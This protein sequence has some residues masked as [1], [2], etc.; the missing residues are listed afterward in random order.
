MQFQPGTLILDGRYRIERLLGVGGSG[1]VY[2]VTQTSWLAA[3][4]ALKILRRGE[5]G[6]DTA[7]IDDYRRRFELE[8]RLAVE[9]GNHPAI[10]RV[11]EGGDHEGS[12]VLVM[13]YMSGGTLKAEIQAA[14]KGITW[15]RCAEVLRD[16]AEG[17]QVLHARGY[18]HRDVK[19][20]NILLDAQQRAKIADLG[21]VQTDSTRT[22]TDAPHEH[23]ASPAYA[24]PEHAN[25]H[26]ALT[27]AADVYALGVMG[28]EMLTGRVPKPAAEGQAP[29]AID[30]NAPEWLKGLIRRML[31]WDYRRRPPDGAAVAEEIARE[32]IAEREREAQRKARAAQLR[33]LIGAVLSKPVPA[34]AELTQADGWVDELLRLTP[35]DAEARALD[36]KVARALRD[37]AGR[38][39][40]E[41]VPAPQPRPLST[42]SPSPAPLPA[43]APQSLTGASA[44]PKGPNK[45]RRAVLIGAGTLGALGLG[46]LATRGGGEAPLAPPTP[47]PTRL[48]PT[49]TAV[50]TSTRPPATSVPTSASPPPT[51]TLPPPPTATPNPVLLRISADLAALTLA[52]GLTMEFVRVPAG[53]FLMGS[54]KS[55]DSLALDDELPQHRLSLPEYWIGKT[56]VTVAQFA[57]YVRATGVKTSASS[58][59][60]NKAAHPVVDVTWD[61]CI[62][63]C[64]WASKLGGG[65]VLL[66]SEAEW[67]K[68]ARG[69]DGRIYPWGNQAP[70]NTRLNFIDSRIGTT[71]PVGQYGAKGQSQYGCDDMAGNVW[72][73]TRSIYKNYPYA[74][75]DGRED[76]SSRDTRVLRGGSFLSFSQLVRCACR[77]GHD[78]NYHFVNLNFRVILRPP[79]L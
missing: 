74:P 35:E 55:K 30:G 19:P 58:D 25:P 28:F 47:A 40:P 56:E 61:D 37:A 1:E 45:T 75:T 66:P 64:G 22:R 49:A 76:L 3:P 27:P 38:K 70:D 57:A 10:V 77:D 36:R 46:W 4:A 69:T 68:A 65:E 13:D 8:G 73:W 60:A 63:F 12:P 44:P 11:L 72:E 6:V 79:S 33:G 50:P 52:Q 26:A 51:S 14:G 20:S 32:L 42:T 9:L 48:P 16:A 78:P 41:P 5:A 54:D 34:Q 7:R 59:V 39:E 53:E 23:P 71:T 15:Q 29:D 18:V 31:A 21:V 62:A 2:L 43:A 67:E 17:L 24:S